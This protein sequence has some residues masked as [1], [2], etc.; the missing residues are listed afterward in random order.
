MLQPW[1][2]GAMEMGP[3][4][5]WSAAAVSEACGTSR[6][7]RSEHTHAPDAPRQ[8]TVAESE[9]SRPAALTIN[10]VFINQAPWYIFK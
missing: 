3:V 1:R 5:N 2:C 7:L 10:S 4:S 6:E 9:E 8:H